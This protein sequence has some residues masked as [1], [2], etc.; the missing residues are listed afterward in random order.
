MHLDYADFKERDAQQTK[1]ACTLTTW[2]SS[3]VCNALVHELAR[4]IHRSIGSQEVVALV[5][6]ESVLD[7]GRNRRPVLMPTTRSVMTDPAEGSL[8]KH[9]VVETFFALK[10]SV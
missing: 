3:R 8:A 2:L 6:E 1:L 5:L 7:A 9:I 10:Q 4:H